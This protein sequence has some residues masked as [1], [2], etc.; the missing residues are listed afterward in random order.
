M[1]R[2][3]TPWQRGCRARTSRA[4]FTKFVR[5]SLVVVGLS[6]LFGA[7]PTSA[8]T[9]PIAYTINGIAGTNGWWR[10]SSGGDYIVVKWTV[11]IPNDQ[12]QSTSG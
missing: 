5:V 11:N 8:D 6:M 4:R 2:R 12:I 7:E 3:P 10:G 9:S 1:S